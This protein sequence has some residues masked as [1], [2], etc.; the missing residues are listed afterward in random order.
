V[1]KSAYN[2]HFLAMMC[3]QQEICQGD[4]FQFRQGRL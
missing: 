4:L 2:E 1:A 3:L